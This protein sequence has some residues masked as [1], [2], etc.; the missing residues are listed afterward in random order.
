MALR[1]KVIKGRRYL[2]DQKSVRRGKKVKTTSTYLGPMNM[3]AVVSLFNKESREF[4]RTPDERLVKH[5]AARAA[6]NRKYDI[7]A[8]ERRAAERAEH[9]KEETKEE[10][11]ARALKEEAALNESGEASQPSGSADASEG[12][13]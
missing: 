3:K 12:G 9:F 2:Y 6:I 5:T 11:W 13:E 10:I 4:L 8:S 1:V 7:K